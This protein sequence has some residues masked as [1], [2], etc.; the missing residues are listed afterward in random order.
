MNE[1]KIVCFKEDEACNFVMA[2][3]CKNYCLMK[4]CDEFRRKKLKKK[5]E[6]KLLDV[7]LVGDRFEII[8]SRAKVH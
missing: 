2:E 5:R 7:S 8:L 3:K 6:R 4:F 1:T